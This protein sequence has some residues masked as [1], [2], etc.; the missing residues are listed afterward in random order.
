MA[1]FSARRH[2]ILIMAHRPA[3]LVMAHRPA[4]L[5]MGHRSCGNLIF[6]HRRQL[7]QSGSMHR[8]EETSGPG[9][10]P[11][12]A[13]VDKNTAYKATVDKDTVRE[14]T[15]RKDT[16]NKPAVDSDKVEPES[17]L[18]IERISKLEEG[19]KNLASV[20]DKGFNRQERWI[21]WIVGFGVGT[22]LLKGFYYDEHLQNRMLEK[23]AD[24]K[25]ELQGEIKDLRNELQ[26]EMKDSRNEL[27]GE[28]KD[29]R[30]ELQ[31]E[32][33]DLGNELQGE[34]KDLGNEL[35]GEIKALRN[36]LYGEIKR[37]N[38][39]LGDMFAQTLQ[40]SLAALKSEILF[41]IAKEELKGT[42]KK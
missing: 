41:A 32:I 23:I 28:M 6:L 2:A 36:E 8:D 39:E 38:K 26:G 42:K 21:R 17:L 14:A 16:A 1:F 13:T 12:E 35:Q 33:K 20:V 9:T 30:N 11:H 34:I 7:S 5:T 24:S 10:T 3:I 40:L 4:I 37:S 15:V 18:P 29:L 19:L 27:Q 25:S 22:V 31:G